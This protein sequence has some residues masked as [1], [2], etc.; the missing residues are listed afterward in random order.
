M[1]GEESSAELETVLDAIDKSDE[2]PTQTEPAKNAPIVDM[3]TQG[4]A[5]VVVDQP[6]PSTPVTNQPKIPW[7]INARHLLQPVLKTELMLCTSC[8]NQEPEHGHEDAGQRGHLADRDHVPRVRQGQ[9]GY[10]LHSS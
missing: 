8:S 5:L 7:Y 1:V 9:L 6:Q 10:A 4:S 2:V 3:V